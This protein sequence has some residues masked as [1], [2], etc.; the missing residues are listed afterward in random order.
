MPCPYF[1]CE[2]DPQTSNEGFDSTHTES[3]VG[4]PSHLT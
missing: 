4:L 2:C 1:I 3:C